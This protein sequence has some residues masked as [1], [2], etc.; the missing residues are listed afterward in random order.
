MGPLDHDIA[1][2]LE[3]PLVA[4]YTNRLMAKVWKQ[5]QLF[6]RWPLPNLNHDTSDVSRHLLQVVVCICVCICAC[7]RVCAGGWNKWSTFI[8]I[9]YQAIVEYQLNRRR[10]K[11]SGHP[12]PP[13]L[14]RFFSFL[15][16]S[17]HFSAYGEIKSMRERLQ[18]QIFVTISD[19]SYISA[20]VVDIICNAS[21][22]MFLYV[23]FHG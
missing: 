9:I 6:V 14:S 8:G 7:A 21:L 4:F 15:L 2:W 1:Y 20:F 5:V 16:I 3:F 18:I 10:G 22:T 13:S 19:F 12:H 11:T 17:S 23:R